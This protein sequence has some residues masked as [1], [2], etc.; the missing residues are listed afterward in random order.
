MYVKKRLSTAS[1]C[2]KGN[3]S[4]QS[5]QYKGNMV[6]VAQSLEL[7]VKADTI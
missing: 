3:N 6:N 7:E 4:Q 2:S 5:R 1:M